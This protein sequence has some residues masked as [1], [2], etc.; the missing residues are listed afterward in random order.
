M[1]WEETFKSHD[2]CTDKYSLLM[3]L[4]YQLEDTC[5]ASGLLLFVF[6]FA[7]FRHI[8]LSVVLTNNSMTFI[9][10]M[11]QIA[12]KHQYHIVLGS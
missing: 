12:F 8:L 4:A 10:V 3:Y 7:L 11:I 9:T 2:V 1:V 6:L 5:R